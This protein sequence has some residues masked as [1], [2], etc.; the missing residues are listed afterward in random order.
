MD[1]KNYQLMT[2]FV[3][4]S[5]V[6]QAQQV[7]NSNKNKIRNLLEK[8]KIPDKGWSSELIELLLSEFSSMDS[9]NFDDSCGLGER[10]GRIFS[11][12][13]LTRNYNFSHGIGRSGDL[14]EVQ[15]KA[16]GSSVLNKLTNELLLD[17]LKISG[18]T[19]VSSC[20]VCPMA[21]GMSL[22]FCMMS[23]RQDKHNAKYVIMPRID[24]KSCIKSIA[25]AGYEAIIIEPLKVGDELVTNLDEIEKKI[26]ELGSESIACILSTTSCFAPRGPDKVEEIA[27]LCLRNNIFHLINNAYGL[28][29]TKLTH[30]INQAM[31]TGRVDVVVQSTDKNLMVPVGGAIL[32]VCE[33]KILKK[34]T[35]FYPGRASFSQS[36]DVLITMLSM[37]SDQY[38]SL[39]KERKECFAYL[40][41]EIQKL[42][43]KYN[44]KVLE[45]PNN[46]ISIAFTLSEFGSDPKK[47]TEIG[48][49]LFT[50]LVSGVRVVVP[51][52]NKIVVANGPLY[53]NFGSHSNS[54]DKAYFTAAAAIGIKQSDIDL[55]LKRLIDCSN[56]HRVLD[57]LMHEKIR[58]NEYLDDDNE[59]VSN[60]LFEEINELEN[61][62][63]EISE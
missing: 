58:M 56:L 12:L 41:S 18:L 45:T 35:E 52:D 50:R 54:T 19:N 63:N 57:K 1:E 53:K 26:S 4:K 48:S 7:H 32:A 28:Q 44:E 10:E 3:P 47:L 42:A 21:T 46:P 23:I 61:E 55:F 5:Y 14:A 39:L 33:K 51:G 13:V 60:D 24:Q 9:N 59:S 43:E 22:A 37:G 27:S 49:M 8:R 40:K 6:D 2:H 16:I 29:S 31:R 25:C 62:S 15:P 17:L 34:I 20:I 38:R 30:I 11:N 36:L